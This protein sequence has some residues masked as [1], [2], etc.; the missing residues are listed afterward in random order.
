MSNEERE[1]IEHIWNG[2][3]EMRKRERKEREELQN[4]DGREIG[5]IKE[6]WK[7]RKREWKKKREEDSKK[8]VFFFN[9]HFYF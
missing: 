5:W 3:S 4:K 7:R 1:T 2:C 6:I 8:N 9:C